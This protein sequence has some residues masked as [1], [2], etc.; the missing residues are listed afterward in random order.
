MQLF[1]TL[2][3]AASLAASALAVSHRKIAARTTVAPDFFAGTQVGQGQS[4]FSPL[5]GDDLIP[6][7]RA[8]H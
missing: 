2:L 1:A 3:I 7:S 5:S 6:M 4:P 8:L